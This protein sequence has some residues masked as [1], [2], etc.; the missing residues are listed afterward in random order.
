MRQCSG[1][2]WRSYRSGVWIVD[3]TPKI[4]SGNPESQRIWAGA[5]YIEMQKYGEY[6]AWRLDTGERVKAEDWAGGL[7]V[8]QGKVTLN[9]ELEIEAF[10]GTTQVHP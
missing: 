1:K 5:K 10:D 8:T 7:A 2:Y 3:K 4:V 6:L 9:E